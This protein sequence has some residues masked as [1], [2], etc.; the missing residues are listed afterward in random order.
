MFLIFLFLCK[1]LKQHKDFLF[2]LVCR[3]GYYNDLN[4]EPKYEIAI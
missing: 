2:Q 4:F 3:Y 1:V